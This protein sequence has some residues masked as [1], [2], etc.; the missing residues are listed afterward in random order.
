MH[1]KGRRECALNFK[2]Q[3]QARAAVLSYDYSGD[4]TLEC[5]CISYGVML[6]FL[7]ILIAL[8]YRIQAW[9]S[10]RTDYRNRDLRMSG[11]Y[12]K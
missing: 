3:W 10:M 5:F 4:Y 12:K 9:W 2:C 11:K 8:I 6:A 1:L 7:I